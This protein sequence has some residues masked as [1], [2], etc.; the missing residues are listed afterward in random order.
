MNLR[1]LILSIFT[2]FCCK[3]NGFN[4]GKD[5]DN[6]EQYTINDT[7][8][9]NDLLEQSYGLSKSNQHDLAINNALQALKIA[10]NV[11]SNF[12]KYKTYV[13]LQ[14]IYSAAGK[15]VLSNKY[16]A[17]AYLIKPKIEKE[18]PTS[19]EEQDRLIKVQQEILEKEQQE[20]RR[21]ME[22]IERLNQ[23]KSISKEE[24]EKRKLEILKKQM[25]IDETK[26]TINSQALRIN[27][28]TSLLQLT[29]QE[30]ENQ[31]TECKNI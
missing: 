30:L 21:K 1:I 26:K 13:A 25:E 22:E 2:L 31:K 15:L 12:A 16:K 18:A 28:T 8:K 4:F 11:S 10:E 24:L 20:L 7:N 17:K 5:K 27:E 14:S 23:D 9:I 29:Q 19:K 6:K 3:I